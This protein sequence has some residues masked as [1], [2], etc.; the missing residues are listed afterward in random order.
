[1][2][3]LTLPLQKM[4]VAEKMNA[5][6]QIWGSLRDGDSRLASPAWHKDLLASRKQLFAAGRSR[7]SPW[8]DAKERIR[9]KARVH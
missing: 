1:M 6:E 8:A 4:T 9:K 2:S 7:F 3:I 5:I